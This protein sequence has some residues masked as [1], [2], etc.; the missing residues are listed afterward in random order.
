MSLG[1]FRRRPIRRGW[2][3]ASLVPIAAVAALVL[4]LAAAAGPIGSASGFEDDD[5][6]LAVNTTFDW[7]GFSPVT[8]TGTAPNQTA[9][10]AASGWAV[11]GLTG[12]QATNAD[13]G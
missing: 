9:S 3:L 8:W 6:N 7:N 10:K 13:S 5:A 1:T 11:T 12:A 2:V 4:V